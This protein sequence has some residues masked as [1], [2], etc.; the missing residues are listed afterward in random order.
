MSITPDILHQVNGGVFSH[1]VK[2]CE[3]IVIGSSKELDARIQTLPPAYGIQH[4]SKGISNL[5]H[6]SG[7]EWKN[8]AKVLLGSIVGIAPKDVIKAARSLLDFIYLAQYASHSEETLKYMEDALD[9]FHT[10]KDV[11]KQLWPKVNFNFPKLHSLLHFTQSI[12]LFGATDNYNT[13]QFEQLHIDLA[14][15]AYHASNKKDEHSQMVTW[16][17]RNEQID[18]F[19]QV[20]EW[21]RFHTMQQNPIPQL[22]HSYQGSTF[23]IAKHPPFPSQDIDKISN[24][25]K[26]P[27][28][29]R[30]LKVFLRCENLEPQ[31]QHGRLQPIEDTSIP[32]HRIPVWT[33]V[34]MCLPDAQEIDGDKETGDAFHAH[35]VNGRFDTVVVSVDDDD[36]DF[37]FQ[38]M[39]SNRFGYYH[40]AHIELS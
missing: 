23:M 22:A 35:P 27:D 26:A 40:Y 34:R 10:H 1:L 30:S 19:Q 33:K 12:R 7:K 21:R 28:F 24:F 39:S 11:F 32:F 31:M 20:I 25:H 13:E 29:L 3:F 14:K 38:G 8:I 6:K 37:G 18:L 17:E 5:T 4:F 36:D 2:W 16:L 9:S 15:D